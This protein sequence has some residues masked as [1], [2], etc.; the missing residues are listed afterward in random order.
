VR[1][2]NRVGVGEECDAAALGQAFEQGLG[3][4]CVGIENAIPDAAKIV[5]I[6]RKMELFREVRVPV[7]RTQTAFRP[8]R[9]E[10]VRFELPQD[11]LVR[12]AIML[13]ELL[14]WPGQINANNDAA[15]VKN[16]RAR[17]FFRGTAQ[18][19]HD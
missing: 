19:R 14:E 8:V 13:T 9:P 6:I 4:D 11:L 1:D 2:V 16:Y 5:E 17:S 7:A 12:Q 10:R 15:N 3:Q 18:E